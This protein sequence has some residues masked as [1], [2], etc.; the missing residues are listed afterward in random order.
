MFSA[1]ICHRF[2]ENFQ[3]LAG[4]TL[5]TESTG[6]RQAIP[7]EPF[8]Q[9]RFFQSTTHRFAHFF[10][11]QWIKILEHASGYFWNAGGVR[12]YGGDAAGHR[13]NERKAEALIKRWDH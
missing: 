1:T 6:P 7:A 12:S 8:S 10:D 11:R 13:L 2:R 3:G 4:A 5:P 9:I